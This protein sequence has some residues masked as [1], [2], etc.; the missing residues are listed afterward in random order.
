M[1]TVAEV[2]IQFPT[3]LALAGERFSL[4]GVLAPDLHL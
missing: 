1:L 2:L 3:R 4:P